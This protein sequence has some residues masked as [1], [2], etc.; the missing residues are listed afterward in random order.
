MQ[1]KM[2]RYNLAGQTLSE[3]ERVLMELCSTFMA[4][5][6]RVLNSSGCDDISAALPHKGEKAHLT[7]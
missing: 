4:F 7:T 3:E 6:S 5:W 2:C 1:N